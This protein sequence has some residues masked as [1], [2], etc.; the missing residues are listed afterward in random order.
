[1]TSNSDDGILTYN[2][3]NHGIAVFVT[4]YPES[5]CSAGYPSSFPTCRAVLGFHGT[6]QVFLHCITKCKG[7]EYNYGSLKKNMRC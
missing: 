2:G 1:M 7:Y 6:K 4:G 5:L 3:E